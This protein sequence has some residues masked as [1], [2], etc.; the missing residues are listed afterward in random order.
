MSHPATDV[1][2]R[3]SAL[4]QRLDEAESTLAAIRAGA[5]DA[6]VVNRGAGERVYTIEAAD[7]RYRLLVESMQQGAAVVLVDGTVL[8]ANSRLAQ[9]FDVDA[10]SLRGYPIHQVVAA[11]SRS[12][13]QDAVRRGR[14]EAVQAELTLQLTSGRHIAVDWSSAPMPVD[15]SAAIGI[16]ITDLSERRRHEAALRTSERLQLMDRRKNEFLATLA[17]EL[18]NPLA[19]I[20]N[21]IALLRGEQ[22]ADATARRALDIVERQVRTLTRLVDDLLDLGRITTGRVALNREPVRVDAVLHRAVETSQPLMHGG[23]HTLEIVAAP[24]DLWVQGDESRLAQVFSNLLNNAAVYATQPSRIQL[25]VTEGRE[26]VRVE[27]RDEGMGIA[28]EMLDVV[29]DM[30][31]QVNPGRHGAG[32]G[33]GIGLSLVRSLVQGHGGRVHAESAGL[34]RGASFIVELPRRAAPVAEVERGAPVPGQAIGPTL[35]VLVVDD[36][37]DAAVS[38]RD[39]LGQHGLRVRVAHDGESALRI[40]AEQGLDVILLDLGMPGFDGFEVCRRLRERPDGARLRVV[41]PPGGGWLRTASAP[42]PP[43]LTCIWSSRCTRSR[44]WTS[45]DAG[46]RGTDARLARS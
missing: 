29:F 5:V 23:G 18:R 28:P 41:A 45:C 24:A 9:L 12:V 13:V 4:Q 17:H 1:D 44:S 40:A 38:L 36:N 8:F 14:T 39:V 7:R 15:E 26:Q 30:F 22:V 42:P 25:I 33:L 6:F 21:A 32:G 19:P 34:G 2:E 16:V 46:S 35:D 43:A 37:E 27:V 11:T 10:A 20:T 31:T 3:L